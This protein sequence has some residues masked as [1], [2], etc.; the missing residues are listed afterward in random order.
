MGKYY[1]IEEFITKNQEH[2]SVEEVPRYAKPISA[3]DIE[4]MEFPPLFW[5]VNEI[6]T[7]GLFLLVAKPKIG[8]SW[9]ALNIAISVALGGMAMSFFKC[10][11]ADVI[12]IAY[13]DNMRRIQS[14]LLNISNQEKRTSSPANL[15]F[16]SIGDFPQLND[17]GLDHLNFLLEQYENTK[18]IIVDTYGRGTKQ[19][20]SRN[21][22]AFLDD[23]EYGALLQEFA[24]KHDVCLL[25]IHH[26]RK[27]QSDDPYDDI[28]GTNGIQAAADGLL[29]L[30][31]QNGKT[32]LHCRG[33]DIEENSYEVEFKAGL[34]KIISKSEYLTNSVE[35]QELIDCFNSDPTKVFRTSELATITGKTDSNISHLCKKL[36]QSGHLIKVKNGCYRLGRAQ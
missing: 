27:L 8:K 3:I 17:G 12:Y 25:I 29:V 9:M 1:S 14:R 5:I 34:W 26:T 23:Y 31:Q 18:L 35:Q 15:Y 13:E 24:I 28:S 16:Y 19:M 33:K 4:K 21:H 36:M 30:K 20:K 22:N 32:F 6:L 7:T 2:F 10:N 11:A